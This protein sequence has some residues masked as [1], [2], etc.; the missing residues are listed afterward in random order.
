MDLND[1]RDGEP[2][3][4]PWLDVV[5][6]EV[7][8]VTIQAQ[9]YLGGSYVEFSPRIGTLTVPFTA[10]SNQCVYMLNGPLCTV[11]FSLVV[12]SINGATDSGAAG[13]V[14]IALPIPPMG[15]RNWVG[16]VA[17]T[18]IT[19]GDAAS[20]TAC[21]LELTEGAPD[22][23]VLLSASGASDSAVSL[24]N[25]AALPFSLNGS[26]SYIAEP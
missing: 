23:C 5:C 7:R 15:G 19:F 8:A 17:M 1:L 4:K 26:V 10:S 3:E 20:P 22:L 6:N 9:N 2:D 14:R 24:A 13:L 21:T 16:P 11:M 18:N 12:T 25:I